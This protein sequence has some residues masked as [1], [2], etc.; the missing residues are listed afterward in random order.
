MEQREIAGR[1]TSLEER[2][3][4]LTTRIEMIYDIV[5]KKFE[6]LDA[7]EIKIQQLMGTVS[8]IEE[9]ITYNKMEQSV[10]RGELREEIHKVRSS[11]VGDVKFDDLVDRLI[12]LESRLSAIEKSLDESVKN[13]PLVLE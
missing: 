11:V 7:A 3:N 12:F 4:A 5:F 9:R 8:E 2:I 6:K 10:D 1:I 13:R